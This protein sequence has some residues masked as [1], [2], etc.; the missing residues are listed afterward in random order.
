M[1]N[2]GSAPSAET[3]VDVIETE[4]VEYVFG[5]PGSQILEVVDAVVRRPGISFVGTRHEQAAAF[6]AEGYARA[7][8]GPG[9]CLSTVGPGATNLVTGVASAFKGYVPVLAL[10]GK[11][12]RWQ[13]ERNTFQEIDQAGLFEPVTRYSRLAA[14]PADLPKLTRKAMRLMTGPPRGPAH[15]NLPKDTQ[16]ASIDEPRQSWESYHAAGGNGPSDDAVRSVLDL[17]READ[18]PVLLAGYDVVWEDVTDDLATF[19]ERVGAP[20][21]T[22]AF[23]LDAFPT[24]HD[25]G[26]GPIGPGFWESANGVAGEADLVVAVGAHFDFLSTHF[27]DRILPASSTKVQIHSDPA[28]VG[29]VYPLEVGVACSAGSFLRTANGMMRTD[30]A[31]AAGDGT[32]WTIDGLAQ[33]K[34]AWFERRSADVDVDSSPL[35]PATT[36][37]LVREGTPD[38]TRFTIDGGNF[39]KHVIRQLDVTEPNSYINNANFGT[40]GSAFPL[41]LG[42]QL[43]VDDPVVCLT[44]DGGMALNVQELETA[45]RES[46]PV[47]VVVFNDAG[48]G[49]VRSYQK[50]VYEERYA[51]VDFV[52]SNFATVADGFGV[53]GRRVDTATAA[54]E[55]IEEGLAHDGPFVVDVETDADA[56]EPP[57]FMQDES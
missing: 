26:M 51:G 20:V 47:T 31:R 21:V 55:A 46:I 15:L 5:L 1:E 23:H 8:R 14:E 41:A 9:V 25:L 44:G 50:Y 3:V 33:R 40:V 45:A 27:R 19:A 11:H 32:E 38:G 7:R 30:D 34:A 12:A 18:R 54:R 17:L 22:S 35:H 53:E 37:Q 28:N 10:T 16:T 48:M 29:A 4:G 57:V 49:N 36:V 52:D 24:D 39:L 6:M 13:Q 42:A 56:L 43:A 2:A